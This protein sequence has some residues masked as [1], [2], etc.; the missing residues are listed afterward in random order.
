VDA[1]L[2]IAD[3]V[4]G[5]ARFNLLFASDFKATVEDRFSILELVTGSSHQC[6]ITCVASTGSAGDIKLGL[7][8]HAGSTSTGTVSLVRNNWYTVELQDQVE[9]D[10]SGTMNLYV[11]KYPG[12]A[13]TGTYAIIAGSCTDTAVTDGHLGTKDRL[14]TTTGTILMDNFIFDD[15]RVYPQ[16]ERYP[17]EVLLTKSGHAFVGPGRID[18]V[19]LM[20]GNSTDNVLSIY[21]TDEANTNDA[22]SVVTELKNTAAYEVVDPAGMPV[23][24][25]NGAYVVLSGT[26]PRAL[27]KIGRANCLTEANVRSHGMAR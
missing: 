15:G 5:Y 16:T 13:A 22:K 25:K 6:K 3:T 17:E 9:T 26:T 21:D 2:N 27:V 4:T 1:T 23:S 7:E 18:N 14:A 10:K 12:P 24:V 20:S 8:N 19:T 11:T